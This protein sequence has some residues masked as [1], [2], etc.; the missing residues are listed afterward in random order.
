MIMEKIYCPNCGHEIAKNTQFCGNCG[1]NVE[2]YLKKL[3]DHPEKEE[4]TDEI[5]RPDNV[6]EPVRRTPKPEPKK[7]MSQQAKI[8]WFVG[9]VVVVLLFGGYM[10]GK[11]YYSAD[12][13]LDRIVAAVTGDGNL[14]KYVT[15][16]DPSLKVSARN[17]KPTQRYFKTHKS[18]LSDFKS[19]I[20]STGR[21]QNFELKENGKYLLFFPKY[22]LSITPAYVTLHTNHAGTRFYQGDKKIYTATA[23]KKSYK[24]GP[25]FPGTYSFATK[26]TV[27]GNKMQNSATRD[28][29]NNDDD[30]DLKLKTVSFTIKGFPGSEVYLNNKKL[31]KIDQTGKYRV[32]NQPDSGNMLVHLEYMV[33]KK[34][35]SSKTVNVGKKLASAQY[36]GNSSTIVPKFSG[37]IS[38]TA[39]QDLFE[40]AFNE[41]QSQ[42]DDAADS[43]KDGQNNKDFNE[44]YQMSKGFADDDDLLSFEYEVDVKSVAPGENGTSVVNFNVKFTFEKE[45]DS[46]KVQ[47]FSYPG[48]VSKDGADYVI[49]SLGANTKI[50][51]KEY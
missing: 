12:K 45:D 9:L 24:A 6:Q 18:Q 28:L 25:Y 11:S 14:A 2:K 36:Y 39:A 26:G 5:Q 13:Q 23:N 32:A 42:S 34:P 40:T 22:K 29:V 27:A 31:G 33:N 37:V 43:F 7:P 41:A 49:D 50:S 48:V 4:Q 17:L 10:F 19:N 16:D 38:K 51:E 47:V 1:Y 3:G 8:S 30:I 35:V 20:R 44:L 21:Y 15:T 46:R